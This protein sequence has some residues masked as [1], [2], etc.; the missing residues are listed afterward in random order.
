MK[1]NMICPSLE[2]TQLNCAIYCMIL[3]IYLYVLWFDII[4]NSI[5]SF[6]YLISSNKF[7]YLPP[8]L[9]LSASVVLV[10]KA[11]LLINLVSFGHFFPFKIDVETEVGSILQLGKIRSF[12]VGCFQ[13]IPESQLFVRKDECKFGFTFKI[14]NNKMAI[15]YY[16][17]TELVITK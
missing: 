17:I 8:N 11:T 5:I 4:Y 2:Q 15:S 6:N 13:L 10:P 14:Q 7:H 3:Q 9:F 16:K 1:Y 12:A